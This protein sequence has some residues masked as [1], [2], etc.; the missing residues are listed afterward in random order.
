MAEYYYC[1]F[2]KK[3]IELTFNS[4]R[5]GEN[6]SDDKINDLRNA[7]SNKK[8]IIVK[9]RYGGIDTPYVYIDIDNYKLNLNNGRMFYFVI[10]EDH[11][12]SRSI[13]LD[14][15]IKNLSVI[16][17]TAEDVRFAAD[18]VHTCATCCINSRFPQNKHEEELI[19]IQKEKAISELSDLA[20]FYYDMDPTPPFRN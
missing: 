5:N 7:K 9:N 16:L 14:K 10:K 15:D 20:K 19:R 11:S 13:Y 12:T 4:L 17:N 6:L 3:W 8:F 1:K 18:Y 2:K